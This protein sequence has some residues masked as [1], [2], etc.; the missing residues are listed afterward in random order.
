M[1]SRSAPIVPLNFYSEK[2]I[3]SLGHLVDKRSI[4]ISVCP[5]APRLKPISSNLEAIPFFCLSKSN[6]CE[7][8]LDTNFTDDEWVKTDE[9]N[10]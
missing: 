4:E 10:S 2:S 5:H 1:T 7:A 9:C 3:E 6:E 8:S